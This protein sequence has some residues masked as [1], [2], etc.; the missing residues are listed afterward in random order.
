MSKSVKV[1]P[2][3]ILGLAML[4]TLMMLS[5]GIM[6]G[7]ADSLSGVKGKVAAISEKEKETI[8]KLFT[9]AQ[10]IE[11]ME[12]K[13]REIALAI[14][15]SKGEIEGLQRA[16]AGEEAAYGKERESLKQVL[17]CY[18][19][20]G[21]GSYLEII[22]KSEDLPDLLR[23]INTLRDLTRNTGELLDQITESRE[24]QSAEKAKLAEK[25]ALVQEEQK[26]LE[27]TLAQKKRLKE[28]MESYL[29]SLKEE[30]EHYQEYLDGLQ[31]AWAEVNSFFSDTVK[32]FSGFI[33]KGGLPADALKITYDFPGIKVRIDEKTI[34][35][36]FAG[37]PQFHKV[38][39]AFRP[40]RV[41]M[42]LPE[43]N[44][45][46]AGKFAVVDGH[47]LEFKVEEGSFYGMLLEKDFIEE[48]FQGGS[49]I[50]DFESELNGYTLKSVDVMDGYLSFSI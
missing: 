33:E 11:Q 48:L 30:R 32:E 5:A 22:L 38:V 31:Q 4:F 49:L 15:K 9:Q 43:E 14:E 34:N 23:R 17:Q 50:L 13:E 36:I 29:A 3:F 10:E 39:F 20:M 44:L 46:L 8:Q 41:E 19:R 27:Q 24:R 18:Q 45:V 47:S 26:H 35:D 6:A 40:G 1:K 42:K 37:A 12:K 2:F 21:P 28:D 16:I 25:L 7:Q